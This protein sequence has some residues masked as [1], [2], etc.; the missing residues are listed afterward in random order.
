MILEVFRWTIVAI[1]LA[2]AIFI[3]VPVCFSEIEGWQPSNYKFFAWVGIG[4]MVAAL[5]IM[6]L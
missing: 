1:L 6:K 4:L 5:I 2:N 3:L